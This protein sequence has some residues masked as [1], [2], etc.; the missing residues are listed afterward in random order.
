M[1]KEFH[2]EDERYSLLP[3]SVSCVQVKRRHYDKVTGVSAFR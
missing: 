2:E 1:V 3:G